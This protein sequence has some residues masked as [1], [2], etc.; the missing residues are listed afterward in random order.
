MDDLSVIKGHAGLRDAHELPFFVSFVESKHA[1]MNEQ[2][3]EEEPP[4]DA[5]RMDP[6]M[7]GTETPPQTSDE[8]LTEAEHVHMH[9]E[10]E[11]VIRPDDIDFDEVE[12]IATLVSERAAHVFRTSTD[13]DETV[14]ALIGN[15][16]ARIQHFAGFFKTIYLKLTSRRIHECP[17]I[18]NM[19]FQLIKHKRTF[20]TTENENAENAANANFAQQVN[21]FSKT[22]GYKAN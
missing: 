17:P 22:C 10:Y 1:E 19:I 5:D 15:S 13:S 8:A 16:D 12:A 2:D 21:A 3:A 18:H 20:G 9:N 11:T 4:L 6:V 7:L 14:R